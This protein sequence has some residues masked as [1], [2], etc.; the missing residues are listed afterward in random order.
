MI[1]IGMACIVV[2][3]VLVMFF[4]SCEE[5]NLSFSIAFLGFILSMILLCAVSKYNSITEEK[6]QKANIS[7]ELFKT[8]VETTGKDEYDVY[9]IM[10]HAAAA[11]MDLYEAVMLIDPDLTQQEAAAIVQI[12]DYKQS[13]GDN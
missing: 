13:K 7:Y 3:F 11:D 6:C 2:S 8:I 10:K 1:S 5:R 4:I 12:S 9:V